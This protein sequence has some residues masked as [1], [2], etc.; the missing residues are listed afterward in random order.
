MPYIEGKTRR[1]WGVISLAPWT[2]AGLFSNKQDA[3]KEAVKLGGNYLVRFG[4][5]CE[6]TDDF[7]WTTLNNQYPGP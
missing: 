3:E 2:F 5:N 1:G 6:G 7:V 4:D